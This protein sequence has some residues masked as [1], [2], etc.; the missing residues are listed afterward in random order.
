MPSRVD[1]EKEF[2]PEFLDLIG[3]QPAPNPDENE[4]ADGAGKGVAE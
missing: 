3:Y 4:L 1:E 2:Q